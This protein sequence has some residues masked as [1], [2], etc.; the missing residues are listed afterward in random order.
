MYSIIIILMIFHIKAAR[1][2]QLIFLHPA[3]IGINQKKFI[4]CENEIFCAASHFTMC[5]T[6]TETHVMAIACIIYFLSV[7]WYLVQ[8]LV[9]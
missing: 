9:L 8:R 7:C 4:F 2:E 1:G 5:N 3:F 6:Q